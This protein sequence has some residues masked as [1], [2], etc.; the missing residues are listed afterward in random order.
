M[1]AAGI[2]SDKDRLEL[3][4]GRVVQQIACSTRHS[5]C[6]QELAYFLIRRYGDHF[7][8]RQNKPVSLLGHSVPEPDYVLAAL[9]PDRY[10]GRKPTAEDVRLVIEVSDATLARDRSSKARLYSLAGIGEYWIINLID[11]RLEVH[12]DPR[13]EVGEYATVAYYARGDNFVSELL[14]ELAVAD[15]IH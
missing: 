3:L 12:T 8:V 4:F 1:V 13:A 10:R 14:G 15:L 9:H 7:I 11:E 6:V 5:F 2:L